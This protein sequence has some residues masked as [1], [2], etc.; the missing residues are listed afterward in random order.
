MIEISATAI[1]WFITLGLVI[2]LITGIIMGKEGIGVSYN[3]IWG[4]GSAVTVGIIAIKLNFGDGLLFA[5]IGTLSI[6][7]LANAFHQHHKEDVLGH[8]D[9]GIAIKKEKQ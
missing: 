1:F 5:T 7:F 8:I 9:E 6:L 2:G 3:L 4:V